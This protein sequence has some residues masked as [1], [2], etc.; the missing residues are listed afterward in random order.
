MEQGEQL[1]VCLG[2]ADRSVG[3]ENQKTCLW[4]M[5]AIGMLSMLQLA[6]L[7]P[8]TAEVAPT[9]LAQHAVNLLQTNQTP[10]AAPQP[11]ATTS[12]TERVRPITTSTSSTT[13][14]TTT[15]LQETTTTAL[16][17]PPE[18]TTTTERRKW[19]PEIVRNVKDER[20]VLAPSAG[21]HVICTEKVGKCR[22]RK[23]GVRFDCDGVTLPDSRTVIMYFGDKDDTN[24]DKAFTTAHEFTHTKEDDLG[25]NQEQIEV[26]DQATG[27]KVLQRKFSDKQLEDIA[28]GIAYANGYRNKDHMDA[29]QYAAYACRVF[30]EY[31]VDL[32]VNTEF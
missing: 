30:R 25:M 4:L 6:V 2:E 11:A 12:T 13:T 24:A 3:V 10:N 8:A 1:P 29:G 5:R 19:C 20:P 14:T 32:C 27:Q 26:I 7:N 22:D 31:G 9:N 21:W 17:V 16:L 15:V 23:R 18:T 28:N